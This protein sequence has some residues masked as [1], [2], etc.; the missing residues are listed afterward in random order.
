[1]GLA[2][3]L[4]DDMYSGRAEAFRLLAAIIFLTSY[5]STFATPIP[6]TNVDCFCD[7]LG[8]I[9]MLTNLQETKTA[10]PNDMITDDHDIFLE[11][12]AT[13]AWCP[14]L[15]LQYLYIPG[16]QDTKS[17][18]PLTV[19]EHHNV[20]CNWLAKQFV[21]VHP[22]LSNTFNNPEMVVARVHLLIDGKVICQ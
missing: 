16:H 19:Q 1:M 18:K 9:T 2:P 6:P 8:I 22:I 4:A 20:E 14:S 10:H 13:V 3:S 12:T 21:K 11:I 15:T 7:N 5:I 17:T